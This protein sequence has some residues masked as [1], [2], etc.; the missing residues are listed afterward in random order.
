MYSGQRNGIYKDYDDWIIDLANEWLEEINPEEN[1][2][3]LIQ[4]LHDTE[5]KYVLNADYNRYCDGVDFRLLF[6]EN[7]PNY[8]YR[9]VYLY[10]QNSPCSVLEMMMGLS[11]RCE[12]EIM[13]NSDIGDDPGRWFCA[14][15]RNMGLDSMDD[16]KYD[17]LFVEKAINRMMYREY[18]PNGTGGLFR[19]K[20]CQTDIRN[21]EIWYQMC[22]YLNE[23]R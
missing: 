4:H 12:N 21:A 5:F 19:I 11:H 15:I 9:D 18:E 13:V 6:A 8:T 17:E 10:L 23:E 1:F 14:M 16:D 2:Y 20:N 3:Q 7:S 22:W